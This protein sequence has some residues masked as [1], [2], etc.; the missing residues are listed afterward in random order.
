MA[1]ASAVL[2]TAVERFKQSISSEDAAM[3][4]MTTLEDVQMA[5]QEIQVSQNQRTSTLNIRRLE[6]FI[7][8]LVEYQ[9]VMDGH[10]NSSSYFS[11]IWVRDIDLVRCLS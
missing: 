10:Y 6:P 2:E 5:I 11:W 7:K 4:Q 3:F 8:S 9:N 1:L